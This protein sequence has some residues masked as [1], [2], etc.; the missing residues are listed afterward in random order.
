MK[1]IYF[2]DGGNGEDSEDNLPTIAGKDVHAEF[3]RLFS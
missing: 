3:V 1:F 2:S